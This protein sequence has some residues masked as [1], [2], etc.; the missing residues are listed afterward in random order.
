MAYNEKSKRNLKPFTGANDPRRQNGRRKGQI[1]RR[2]AIRSLLSQPVDPHLIIGE[3]AKENLTGLKDATYL[4]AILHTL[5]NQA[6]NNDTRA[7]DIFL[8]ELRHIEK[9][10]P[11]EPLFRQGFKIEVVQSRDEIERLEALKDELETK[12]GEEYERLA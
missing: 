11:S 8:R 6:L 10:E 2:T 1:N 4:D 7:S 3:K 9:E 5:A 12:Y